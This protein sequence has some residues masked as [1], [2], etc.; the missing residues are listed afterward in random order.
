MAASAGSAQAAPCPDCF[1]VMLCPDTQFYTAGAWQPAGGEH[2]DLTGR[3]VCEFKDN[4]VEPSTGKMM[5]IVFV[6]PTGS[7]PPQ[8]LLYLT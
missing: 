7:N 2:F 5:P 1:S 8:P 3:W 6:P 4:F